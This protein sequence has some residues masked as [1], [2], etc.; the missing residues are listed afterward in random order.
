[1]ESMFRSSY[2]DPDLASWDTSCITNM[3]SMFYGSVK[4]NPDVSNWDTSS[5]TDM[6]HMFYWTSMA[7]PDVSNWDTSSVTDMGYMFYHAVRANPDVSNWN[8]SSVTD[9]E[10]MFWSAFMANPDVSNWDVTSVDRA[11]INGQSFKYAL[12]F[13]YHVLYLFG[14]ALLQ[15]VDEGRCRNCPWG[16][17]AKENGKGCRLAL[18]MQLRIPNLIGQEPY[19]VTLPF[20]VGGNYNVHVDWGDKSPW[21]AID[22]W[23]SDH[24]ADVTHEYRINGLRTVSFYG[25]VSHISFA[26]LPS[27]GKNFNTFLEG[28]PNLGDG[29]VGLTDLRYGFANCP[30]LVH[31][32]G[33]NVSA[34]TNMESIFENSPQVIPDIGDW[35]TSAVTNMRAMF[36]GAAEANP[37]VSNWDTSSVTDMS[38][39]FEDAVVANPDVSRWDVS[40][41][42]QMKSM[43]S[44]ADMA[45]PDVSNWDT[46]WVTNMNSMFYDASMANPDVSNWDTSSVTNTFSGADMANPDVSN[47]NTSNVTNM[48]SC[49]AHTWVDRSVN[50]NGV[51]EPCPPGQQNN[52][53]ETSDSC[54]FCGLGEA[55]PFS[56]QGCSPCGENEESSLDRT[57]CNPCE[58]AYY[59]D[60]GGAACVMCPQGTSAAAGE[61]PGCELCGDNEETVSSVLPHTVMGFKIAPPY[62]DGFKI[63]GFSSFRLKTLEG[64]RS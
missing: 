23:T 26:N 33:G 1:M 30:N 63:F 37:D 61:G 12:F 36:K 21:T 6:G 46:S 31:F 56:G 25:T 38:S 19:P 48:N 29:D 5:V 53:P 28:V 32:A 45:N 22:E 49:P 24:A 2:S 3:N 13:N 57:G 54:V 43:F 50:A 7:N 40:S 52:N 18:S 62:C 55:A 16:H 64:I 41:V 20:V 34:V 8:T 15:W 39:M 4:A 10:V 42:M 44:G 27:W 9:M 35:D 11:P 51:C 60:V 14:C 59:R 58:D 17:Y 47:W